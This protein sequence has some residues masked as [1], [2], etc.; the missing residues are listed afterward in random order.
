MTSPNNAASHK[1]GFARARPNRGGEDPGPAG[2]AE[3]FVFRRFCRWE[4]HSIY[5]RWRT[6]GASAEHAQITTPPPLESWQQRQWD[7]EKEESPREMKRAAA[8][9]L[10]ELRLHSGGVTPALR[11]MAT[12]AERRGTKGEGK[13][14]SVPSFFCTLTGG[15]L[16][17]RAGGRP[18]A[19][20]AT[21]TASGM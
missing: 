14:T 16:P 18:T 15:A 3:T 20:R 5:L 12:I 19:G 7:D 9:Y 13:R 2:N 8:T 4:S 11:N 1:T 17:S 10:N 6:P 21:T